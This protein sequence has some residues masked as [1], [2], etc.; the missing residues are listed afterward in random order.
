VIVYQFIDKLPQN[1]VSGKYCLNERALL[2]SDQS[3]QQGSILMRNWN[4]KLFYLVFMLL[5]LAILTACSSVAE[6]EVQ[7]T[8]T[9]PAIAPAAPTEAPTL[10][11]FDDPFA[12]CAA[13]GQIDA[14][15]GRYTGE[16]MSDALFKAYLKA[17]GLNADTEY[18]D[19]FQKMTIWRC[20]DSKVYA[21]NFG[22][23]IPCDSKANTD[24]T[25]TQAMADFCKQFPDEPFIPMSV[26]GHSVIYS[27]HCVK[28]VPELLDQIDTVDA[29]GYQ[30]SFW[31]LI[32]PE[33]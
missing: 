10:Q 7:T 30:T 20:M 16:L 18:P 32:Q 19:N 29:A 5:L 24:K 25:P 13:V 4:S 1:I 28:G 12:Y 2:Y 15:D 8:P 17:A 3:N 14:P 31:Q 22:A 33:P 27:W 11:T 21:C 6:A 23:N 26:T 9:T